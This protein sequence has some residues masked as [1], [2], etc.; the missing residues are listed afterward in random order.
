MSEGPA[1]RKWTCNHCGAEVVKS[2]DGQPDDWMRVHF[3]NPPRRDVMDAERADLCLKCCR[4][5]FAFVRPT[6]TGNK[7]TSKVAG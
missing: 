4:E 1:Y 5:F 6:I 7:G 3:V 2:S